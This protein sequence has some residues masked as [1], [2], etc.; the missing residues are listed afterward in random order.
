MLERTFEKKLIMKNYKLPE[1]HFYFTIFEL[2]IYGSASPKKIM[3]NGLN[4]VV[5]ESIMVAQ[6]QNK[7]IAEIFCFFELIFIQN[8]TNQSSQFS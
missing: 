4:K 6:K 1:S 7:K 3:F 2:Y 5:S 8:K